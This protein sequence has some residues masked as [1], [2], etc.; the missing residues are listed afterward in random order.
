[1][2]ENLEAAGARASRAVR[3]R[4]GDLTGGASDPFVHL[5]VASGHS[6]RHGASHPHVLVERAAE[7]GMDLL[8]LTD[9][10]GLYGAV[11]FA[12]ACTA[13]G[14][15]PVLGVDLAVA[16]ATHPALARRGDAGWAAGA[17]PRTHQAHQA[18]RRTPARGG[19]SVD[20]GLP[21]VTVLAEGKAGWGALCRLVSATHLAGERGT[22]VT[23]LELI[24]DA[25]ALGSLV[26]LLGPASELGRCL[27][28]RRAD[29]A[30]AYLERWRAALPDPRTGL[31]LEVVHHRGRTEGGESDAARAG[32]LAGFGGEHHVPVVLTNLVRY[33]DRR[34]APVADVLDSARRLVP[35][36]ARHVERTTGEGYLKSGKEMADVADEV[37]RAAGWGPD[38]G[39]RLLARTRALAERCAL[40]PR[41][42]LGI[43][44]VHFPELAVSTAGWSSAGTTSPRGGSSAG[45]G[46]AVL[47][48]RCEAGLG[49]RGLRVDRTVTERLDAELGVIT[50]LGYPTYFLAVADVVDLIRGMG[51]RCAARGSGAGSLVTYLLRISDV[52]PLEHGLLMERFLSPLRH[53]LPDIDIDVESARRTEV[54]ERVLGRYGGERCACVAMTDLPGAPCDP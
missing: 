5:H 20:P 17:V 39:D 37:A 4:T 10:D 34:D 36:D 32:R 11:R 22:P 8:G 31:V 43:G 40:D 47:R 41:A 42:D 49:S 28:H 54:Y 14:I 1:V 13:A 23:T 27:A 45:S 48:A 16:P 12:K 53:Q 44:E 25:A 46:D 52:D 35:L 19:A 50:S 7:H 33:A 9:R 21:R 15:R 26:V 6:L 30:R 51:V 38:G 24:A 29:L 3:V 2:G 18:P